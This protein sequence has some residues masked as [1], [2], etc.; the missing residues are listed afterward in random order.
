MDNRDLE[1]LEAQ[2]E[3]VVVEDGEAKIAPLLAYQLVMAEQKIKEMEAFR[4][5]YKEKI[6]KAMEENGIM[7]IEN[8]V[9]RINYYPPNT[10]N[11]FDSK[12]FKKD[13]PE[14]AE[15]YITIN[16]KKSYIKITCK[17]EDGE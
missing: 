13:H 10:E 16:D 12:K 17:S 4:N 6:L 8:D 14:L 5:N 15:Q 3:L 7:K 9:I 2:N 11:K 1:T